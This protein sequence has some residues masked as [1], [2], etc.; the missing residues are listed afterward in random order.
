[1][2]KEDNKNKILK[3]KKIIKKKKKEKRTRKRKKK[4]KRGE[5]GGKRKKKRGAGGSSVKRGKIKL[6]DYLPWVKD[7]PRYL[8][9]SAADI[10]EFA[11]DFSGPGSDN[12]AGLS[13]AVDD[14]YE[15]KKAVVKKR[16]AKRGDQGG[17]R[18][19]DYTK[20]RAFC[21][22][23]EPGTKKVCTAN[24]TKLGSLKVHFTG[25]HTEAA[26]DKALVTWKVGQESNDKQA[27]VEAQGKSSKLVP[28]SKVVPTDY[29]DDYAGDDDEH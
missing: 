25:K 26:W 16:L 29:L 11:E 28:H 10:K 4:K 21:Y 20:S 7:D 1:M 5:K 13:E 14:I 17:R 24:F 9:R 19:P 12:A 18:P 22:Y 8:S 15:E 23:V 2:I 3:N 6:F 27:A